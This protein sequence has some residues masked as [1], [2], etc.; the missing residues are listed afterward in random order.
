MASLP[1]EPE[2]LISRLSHRP[3][4]LIE[5][6]IS[7]PDAA[8]LPK[9]SSVQCKSTLPS[10][11]ILN[12]LPLEILFETLGLLDAQSLSRMSRVSAQ[13]HNAV[14]SL[15]AYSELLEHAPEAL[16]ALVQTELISL[17]SAAQ[18]Q[19]TLRTE[20]C[21][22][23]LEFGAYLFLPT[24]VRCCWECLSHN[25]ALRVISSRDAE[26]SFGLSRKYMRLLPTTRTIMGQYGVSGNRLEHTHK[27]VSASMARELAISAHGSAEKLAKILPA[28][29]SQK[30]VKEARFLQG[31]P[32]ARD[33]DGRSAAPDQGDTLA[34]GFF[35]VASLPFPSLRETDIIENG[36]WCR[37][38]DR[39]LTR[40]ETRR[41]SFHT[42]VG[43]EP[44]I[45]AA[46]HVPML[47][48]LARRA[49]SRVQ[50]LEHVKDC[51]GANNL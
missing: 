3:Y 11:G 25:P 23:C 22:S 26:K 17:H 45:P 49:W 15:P 20:R 35:G 41:L 38:C 32:F 1:I 40:F 30:W 13:A 9:H 8:D 24:C 44:Q 10:M 7:P 33:G 34:D 5:S 2:E 12:K 14:E 19:A 21:Q 43:T 47:T 29:N 6:M 31:R 48:G 42:I 46:E 16:R 39:Q 4:Y 36:L 51:Y 37:G 28:K 18:L 50:F 27:L